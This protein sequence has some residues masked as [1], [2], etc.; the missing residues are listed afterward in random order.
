METQLFFSKPD[1]FSLF[2]SLTGG[3]TL[4]LGMRLWVQSL[5]L[6]IGLRIQRC[7][8]PWCR[9]QTQ[10]GSSIAVALAQANSNSSEQTPSPGTS[11]C[12]GCGPKRQKTKDKKK[13]NLKPCILMICIG[14]STKGINVYNFLKRT[15]QLQRQIVQEYNIDL[16]STTNS[17]ARVRIF[18]NSS[19]E[20]A[21]S[22]RMNNFSLIFTIVE[23]LENLV[24][25][26]TKFKILCVYV[27]NRV[28]A[29]LIIDRVP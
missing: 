16:L 5:A 19:Q 17:I 15:W 6:L 25:I 20:S 3:T 11:M 2:L 21:G 9:S 18:H 10:L 4:C 22:G 28:Q 26:K 29:Q 8:E 13:K 27:Q 23:F 12:C 14:F 1:P 7:S 24:Y